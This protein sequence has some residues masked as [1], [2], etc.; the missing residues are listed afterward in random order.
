ML[1][2]ETIILSSISIVNESQCRT[3]KP[4]FHFPVFPYMDFI[5]SGPGI[6]WGLF[7]QVRERKRDG[8][9]K[10]MPAAA[11]HYGSFVP[12]KMGELEIQNQCHLPILVA[13]TGPFHN[14]CSINQHQQ[15]RVADIHIKSVWSGNLREGRRLDL[16]RRFTSLSAHPVDASRSTVYSRSPRL[17]FGSQQQWY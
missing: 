15:Q 11:L 5:L 13:R 8:G 9:V 6:L 2:Y 1:W 12:L 14:Y 16:P 17:P 7:W 4:L 10:E 3:T